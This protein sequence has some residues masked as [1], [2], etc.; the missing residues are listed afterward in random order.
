MVLQVSYLSY[1]GWNLRP[2]HAVLPPVK[3]SLPKLYRKQGGLSQ[4][5]HSYSSEERWLR[6]RPL[7]TCA[8]AHYGFLHSFQ[9]ACFSSCFQHHWVL[10]HNAAWLYLNMVI[11]VIFNTIIFSS[12]SSQHESLLDNHFGYC[13][14]SS[15]HRFSFWKQN[16]ALHITAFIM[17][18]PKSRGNKRG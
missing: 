6:S 14:W 5:N 15:V 9:T 12:A 8:E 11:R 10:Q 1:G 16:P 4:E 3:M 18:T 7:G 17:Q 13:H 2:Q